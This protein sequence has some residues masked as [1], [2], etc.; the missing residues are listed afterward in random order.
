MDPTD[1]REEEDM[2]ER[3]VS[4]II[5]CSR[6]LARELLANCGGD[7]NKVIDTFLG[8]KV[9][10][11]EDQKTKMKPEG[12]GIA[13]GISSVLKRK[14]SAGSIE[15]AASDSDEE[16]IDKVSPDETKFKNLNVFK[17]I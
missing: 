14:R 16:N 10:E 15:K 7:V 5:E 3:T 13:G 4:E 8:S 9:S 6:E 2:K 1:A 11:A 12:A 17:C